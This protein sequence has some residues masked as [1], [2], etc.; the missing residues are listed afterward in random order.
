MVYPP[1]FDQLIGFSVSKH[2]HLIMK[3]LAPTILAIINPGQRLTLSV[4]HH[5]IY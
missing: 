2:H 1:T 4:N 5:T 3:W